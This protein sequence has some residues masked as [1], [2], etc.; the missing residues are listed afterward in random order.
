MSI[1][2]YKSWAFV[3]TSAFHEFQN[4]SATRTVPVAIALGIPSLLLAALTAYRGLPAVA[5]PLLWL[6]A[7]LAAIPWVAT[8]TVMI[9]LQERL[10][11]EGP[12]AGLVG[13]LF[14]KDLVLRSV[15]PTLQSVILFV[16]VVRCKQ[17]R[18]E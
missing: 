14:W 8:P 4:A 13:E 18:A 7:V 10:A 15:P 12:V 9:P 11:A 17:R 16:S 5:R 1:V 6:A 2:H 3:P